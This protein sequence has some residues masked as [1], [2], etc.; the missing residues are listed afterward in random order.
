MKA[1]VVV[2]VLL[3]ATFAHAFTHSKISPPPGWIEN[4]LVDQD[5]VAKVRRMQGVR[6]VEHQQW[7]SPDNTASLQVIDVEI[8]NTNDQMVEGTEAGAVRAAG[9]AHRISLTRREQGNITIVDHVVEQTDAR[10]H[11]RRHYAFDDRGGFH[12]LS[13]TCVGPVGADVPACMTALD[14]VTLLFKPVSPNMAKPH[15]FAYRI[16][17]LTGSFI[18]VGLLVWFVIRWMRK[19][20]ARPSSPTTS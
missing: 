15:N 17:Q 8:D 13:A 7:T 12:F 6:R 10:L 11:V 9:S 3:I 14:S 19:K 20:P 18:L 16:G 1:V 4:S 2:G 5:K